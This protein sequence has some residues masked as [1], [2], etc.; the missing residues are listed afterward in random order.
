MKILQIATI[1]LPVTPDL[2]YGGTERVISYLD[3]VYTE[4]N[5]ESVV[6]APG[7]SRVRGKLIETIPRSAWSTEKKGD[8]ERKIKRSKELEAKHYKKCIEAL[9]ENPDID[10]V[11]DHPGSGLISSREFQDVISKLE[12]PILQTLHGPFFERH[13]SKY[14]LWQR[15]AREYK[16][17]F[18]NA[19]SNSQKREF[20][21]NGFEI[22]DVIYHGIPTGKFIPSNGKKEDY[23]FSIGRISPEKSQH[24]AIEVAKRTGRPLI[25]AG[26]VHSVNESYWREMVEPHIDGKQI[27]F[28][29]PKT[30]K[31]KIPLYQNAAA[32]LFPIQWSEPFGLVMIEAMACGTPVIAYD[33]GS[34]PEV[35]KDGET[36]FIIPKTNNKEIDLEAMVEAVNNIGSINSE[37]CR[38]HVV[39]NFSIENEARNYLS[40]YERLINVSCK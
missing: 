24:L 7:D 8:S 36:G 29:G 1:G 26:E 38:N 27:R 6:A 19:I 23:L 37:D 34:V 4:W 13:K 20:E 33:Q 39:E 22:E 10:I 17:V 30:D 5:H 28:V 9:L 2:M 15:T 11:H 14:E 16:R 12:I 35:I 32:Y 21:E 40:L 3:Q 25:I 18:F 31:E